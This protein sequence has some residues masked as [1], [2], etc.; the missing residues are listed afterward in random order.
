MERATARARQRV[1]I[2]TSVTDPETPVPARAEEQT[3]MLAD[4]LRAPMLSVTSL[5]LQGMG[6]KPFCPFDR[7]HQASEAL[8]NKRLWP[9]EG[10][11]AS[12]QHRPL[13]SAWHG[14]HA[15]SSLK[16]S[17]TAAAVSSVRLMAGSHPWPPRGSEKEVRAVM[18]LTVLTSPD[19]IRL[20]KASSHI[21]GSPV[22]GLGSKASQSPSSDTGPG[23]GLRRSPLILP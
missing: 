19:G 11:S 23:S 14:P 4:I 10:G 3:V 6:T 1:G 12:C 21:R 22:S 9:V 7:R 18:S 8:E 13:C 5:V 15:S 17:V 2:F 16:N 20:H